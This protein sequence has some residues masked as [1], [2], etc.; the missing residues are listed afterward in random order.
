M[1]TML[2]EIAGMFAS[3]DEP[4]QYLVHDMRFHQTIAA[5][6][7]NRILTVLMH[8][9]STILFDVRSKTVKRAT[10]LKESAEM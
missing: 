8:M 3:L 6:S 5:A 4:E 7:G 1:A 2:E 10:D 9:V